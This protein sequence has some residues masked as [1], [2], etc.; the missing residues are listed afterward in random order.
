M[1]SSPLCQPP[2]TPASL[3]AKARKFKHYGTVL[4]SVLRGSTAQISLRLFS[5]SEPGIHP[6]P[7]VFCLSI[8]QM[9]ILVVELL[10]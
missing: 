6:S 5:D 4:D 9:P 1:A 8:S 2:S 3:D 7:P 10:P